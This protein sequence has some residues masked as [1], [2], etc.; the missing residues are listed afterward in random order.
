MKKLIL[1]AA[2]I[3]VVGTTFGQILQKGN[4]VGFHF[5]TITLN[6]DVTMDQF[7]DFSVTKYIPEFE[8]NFPGVK[9]YI[10]KG[11]RGENESSLAM[12]WL[13][14]SEETRNKYFN[15]DESLNEL[16]K[17]A[18]E[19]L[20]PIVEEGNKLGTFTTTYTDWVIQ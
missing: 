2:L 16:G 19:K 8:K 4:L 11:I 15:E 13:F 14:E 3:L 6:P 18:Q 7:I 12:I 10:A 5:M 20:Q 1:T 17:S 9:L